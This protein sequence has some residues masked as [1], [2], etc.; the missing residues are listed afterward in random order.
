MFVLIKI[1]VASTAFIDTALAYNIYY[2]PTSDADRI[3]KKK[4]NNSFFISNLERVYY[5]NVEYDVDCL[6]LIYLWISSYV[7]Y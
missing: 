7:A 3:K 4:K 6:M 2:F 1:D 5:G